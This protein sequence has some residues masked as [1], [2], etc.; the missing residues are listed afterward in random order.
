MQIAVGKRRAIRGK[1][2]SLPE[3]AWRAEI[4]RR[5]D[6]L[7][8]IVQDGGQRVSDRAKDGFVRLRVA[9]ELVR[10][11]EKGICLGQKHSGEC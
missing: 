4:R 1:P 2:R 9:V 10:G 7:H 5:C 6:G 3:S 11:T 8:V